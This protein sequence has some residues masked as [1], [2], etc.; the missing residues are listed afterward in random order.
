MLKKILR[1][2]V[3][4]SAAMVIMLS[5]F[6]GETFAKTTINLW[7]IWASDKPQGKNLKK[8]VKE[9]E[10]LNP[11]I[12]VEIFQATDQVM[13]KKLATAIATGEAPD[14][15]AL[16]Y[17]RL[18][19][20]VDNNVVS[21]IDSNAIKAMGYKSLMDFKKAWAPGS[22]ESYQANGQF[23]GIPSQFNI[24]TWIINAKHFREAGLDPAKDYPK[25]WEDVIEVGKKLT[26]KKDGRVI[27]QAV[28]FPFSISAAWYLLEFEP[29]IR[30]LGGSLVSTDGNEGR[31]NTPAGIKTMETLKARFDVGISDKD[32]AVGLSYH[33]QAFPNGEFSMTVGG[34]WG[35]PR[36]TRKA[37]FPNDES[38]F[39]PIHAPTFKGKT[40]TSSTTG[41]S[42]AVTNSSK[43]KVAAWKLANFIT[44]QPSRHLLET[45]DIIPRAGWSQ[46]EGAKKIPYAKHWEEAL[47]YSV[48][49]AKMPKYGE[50]SEVIK[51][52]IQSILLSGKD[53]KT[54]LDRANNEINRILKSQ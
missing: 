22:L 5:L 43:N 50:V 31:I 6:V 26:I 11:D 3:L 45:G 30:Q 37:D 47:Q 39:L 52:A 7:H 27:R 24:Y 21:P 2:S 4:I 44:S 54:T 42:W 19:D 33:S 28:S 16:T 41:W 10:S 12:V 20:F 40:T 23:Y 13:F 15:F 9:Y 1:K 35:I 14:V 18:S 32:I 34:N 17:R 8:Y 36:W 38:D 49:L 46:T 48:P 51:K 53:I 25:T 29:M